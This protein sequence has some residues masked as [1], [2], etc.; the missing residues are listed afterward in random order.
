MVTLP[1]GDGS[2]MVAA[3]VQRAEPRERLRVDM[4]GQQ[5]AVATS[6]SWA[7]EA[8]HLGS[9]IGALESS[10]WIDS[11]YKLIINIQHIQDS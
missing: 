11:E 10:N 8:S 9:Q 2:A 5:S 1:S 3:I 4:R 6:A 7:V